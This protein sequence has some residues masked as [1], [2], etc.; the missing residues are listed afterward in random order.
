M[1]DKICI[2]ILQAFL[3]LNSNCQYCNAAPNSISNTQCFN[4]I[5]IFEIEN[6][7]YRAGHTSINKNGDIVI[8][9]S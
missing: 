6:K 7:Y 1:K 4:N 2:F 8:E 3:L 5:K 9:Y